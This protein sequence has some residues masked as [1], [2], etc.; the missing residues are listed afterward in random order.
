MKDITIHADIMVKSA[1]KK[2]DI[3]ATKVLF[4]VDDFMHLIGDIRRFILSGG[5]II[6]KYRDSI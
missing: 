6:Y 3:C 1:L 5:D 2:L 4:V